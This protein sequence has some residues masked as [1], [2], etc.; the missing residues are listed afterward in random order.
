MHDMIAREENTKQYRSI[1]WT[2]GNWFVF[3]KMVQ[4]LLTI[5]LDTGV[6]SPTQTLYV[7]CWFQYCTFTLLLQENSE[8]IDKVGIWMCE[9]W[10]QWVIIAIKL[11]LEDLNRFR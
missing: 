6:Q 3:M 2:V 1:Y 8:I 7:Q 10:N 9:L 4:F 11:L 5:L